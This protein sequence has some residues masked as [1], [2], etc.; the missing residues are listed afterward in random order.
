MFDISCNDFWKGKGIDSLL[1]IKNQTY[2][3]RLA[4]DTRKQTQVFKSTFQFG[5]H[6]IM[7][8]FSKEVKSA[9]S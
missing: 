8:L 9:V 4:N 1:V 7:N 2:K 3:K 5:K 6:E